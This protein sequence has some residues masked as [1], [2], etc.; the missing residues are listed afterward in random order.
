VEGEEGTPSGL[1]VAPGLQ[2]HGVR[3]VGF[4]T[5]NHTSFDHD[6]LVRDLPGVA[7]QD[8]G[9]QVPVVE[10]EAISV[11]AT[12]TRHRFPM[13]FARVAMVTQSTGISVIAATGLRRVL[14]PARFSADVVGARILVV[15]LHRVPDADAVGAMVGHGTRVPVYALPFVQRDVFAPFLAVTNVLGTAVVVVTKIDVIPAHLQRFIHV[16]I[17]IIVDSVA[18][19]FRR[20]R[21]VA[22]GQTFRRAYPHPGAHSPL[23]FD[24]AAGPQTQRSGSRGTRAFSRIGHALSRLNAVHRCRGQT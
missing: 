24:F 2:A 19:L 15:A 6:T 17:A 13:A 7:R 9:A 16:S 22:G 5:F 11:D 3:P 10:F 4:V 18:L 1:G 23:V 21:G 20:N 8:A 12:V 14:A